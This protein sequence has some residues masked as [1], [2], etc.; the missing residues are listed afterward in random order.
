MDNDNNNDIVLNEKLNNTYYA[1]N[2][3]YEMTLEDIYLNNTKN[4]RRKRDNF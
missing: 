1:A 3:S 2:G 4:L